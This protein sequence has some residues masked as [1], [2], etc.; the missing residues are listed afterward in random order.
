MFTPLSGR[1][2]KASKES[3]VHRHPSTSAFDLSAR[4]ADFT[5]NPTATC[6]T[7]EVSYA[8][9][10][11]WEWNLQNGKTQCHPRQG[12]RPCSAV[13]AVNTAE[14]S[15]F[16][17][18]TGSQAWDFVYGTAHYTFILG[19]TDGRS[20]EGLDEPAPRPSPTPIQGCILESLS[21]DSGP[22]R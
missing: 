17:S 2:M 8:T 11:S 6:F 12:P 3:W 15:P 9:P 20:R 18:S 16:L 7:S 14:P 22:G 13:G 4:E 10:S 21:S 19:A 1:K 5:S